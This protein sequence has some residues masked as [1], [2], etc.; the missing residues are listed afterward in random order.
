MPSYSKHMDTAKCTAYESPA[1]YITYP[2]RHYKVYRGLLRYPMIS[3]KSGHF[4]KHSIVYT[5]WHD[6]ERERTTGQRNSGRNS[7][8]IKTG[9]LLPR[10]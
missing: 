3:S 6:F 2:S 5:T 10:R 8:Q 7:S 9:I 1:V 4:V